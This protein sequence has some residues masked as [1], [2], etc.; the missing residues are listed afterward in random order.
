[1]YKVVGVKRHD[2]FW[3]L[4]WVCGY[5]NLDVARRTEAVDRI[6]SSRHSV[7]RVS[8]VV[9]GER[10]GHVH[11]W[12]ARCAA[13]AAAAVSRDANSRRP[14]RCASLALWTVVR[15]EAIVGLTRTVSDRPATTLLLLRLWHALARDYL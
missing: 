4:D 6:P 14:P 5:S 3:V 7:H 11:H 8:E 13:A 2:N 9:N 15:S 10:L 1:V 12:L